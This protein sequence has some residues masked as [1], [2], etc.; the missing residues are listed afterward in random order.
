MDQATDVVVVAV[1]ETIF[2]DVVEITNAE[3]VVAVLAKTI[4]IITVTVEIFDAVEVVEIPSD[5][6]ILIVQTSTKKILEEK[7]NKHFPLVSVNNEEE[8]V[9]QFQVLVDEIKAVIN[10]LQR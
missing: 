8:V 7:L 6:K 5:N 1:V 9:I 2:N 3:I 10:L 4:I